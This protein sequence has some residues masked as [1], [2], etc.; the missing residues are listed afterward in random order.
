MKYVAPVAAVVAAALSAFSPD[1]QSLVASHPAL[2][3]VFGALAVLAA[4]F[5]PQPKQPK[6]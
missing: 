6:Q 2:A 4:A 1:I 5:A 3:G